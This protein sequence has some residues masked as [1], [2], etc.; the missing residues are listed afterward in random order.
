MAKKTRKITITVPEEIA[1]TLEAWRESGA[2]ASVSEYATRQLRV[3]MARAGAIR[4]SETVYGG[5][6]GPKRPPLDAI[7][8]G[9]ALQGLAPLTEQQADAVSAEAWAT[10]TTPHRRTA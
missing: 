2:I 5:A 10:T 7:N 3:A 6:G 8:A 4:L 1:V 9:R